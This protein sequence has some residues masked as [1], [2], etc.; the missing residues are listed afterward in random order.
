MLTVHLRLHEATTA[1]AGRLRL[2]S[3]GQL[4]WPLGRFAN[5]HE[6]TYESAEGLFTYIDGPCELLLPPGPFQL[7]AAAGP[8]RTP[9]SGEYTLAAGQLA[10]RFVLQRVFD[11]RQRGWYAA[12][13]RVH[14]LTPHGAL[15]QARG[16]DLDI[17]QLLIRPGDSLVAFS[18]Q[19]VAVQRGGTLVAVNTLN[20]SETGG[21]LALLHAHRPVFPLST[22]ELPWALRDWCDQCH[23]KRG[24]VV[25]PDTPRLT[26][27]H[28]AREAFQAAL[29][30]QIDALEVCSESSLVLY[31]ELLNAGCRLALI[32]SSGRSD[33]TSRLGQ[34][35]TYAQLL[36]G[37]ELSLASYL[38]AIRAGRCQ[39]SSG[40]V[41]E[42]YLHAEGYEAR[43]FPEQT[44]QWLHNGVEVAS[45]W[46]SVVL[47][48]QAVKTGWLAARS[49]GP[50]GWA[51]SSALWLEGPFQ[52]HLSERLSALVAA[53]PS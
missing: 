2:L 47:P 45:A 43:V 8:C 32:G 22:A 28:P 26:E 27:Q 17:V 15:L 34:V 5:D 25:W 31:Q 1:L 3:R 40:P 10:L 29:Q 11:P 19:E 4:C 23:R 37:E 36:P 41:L 13:L 50:H 48:R 38:E 44:V 6:S 9:L 35:R 51:H 20:E 24:L 12:D 53:R 7:T 52:P 49:Q 46:A 33:R 39:A 14:G 42:L 18:G 21:T 16:E 30:G